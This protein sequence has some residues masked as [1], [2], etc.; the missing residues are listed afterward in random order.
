MKQEI[1]ASDSA[2]APTDNYLGI[3]FENAFWEDVLS[4]CIYPP[5]AAFRD[6]EQE[7]EDAEGNPIP[8]PE[9]EDGH[10]ITILWRMD[11]PE[12][13]R[14][15]R[16]RLYA[17][18]AAFA[19]LYR[20]RVA[21]KDWLRLVMVRYTD[22]LPHRSDVPAINFRLWQHSFMFVGDT[23]TLA[24]VEGREYEQSLPAPLPPADEAVCKAAHE[25]WRAM[26]N[27]R[28]K[29]LLSLIHDAESYETL[30]PTIDEWRGYSWQL[31]GGYDAALEN[32]CKRLQFC[33]WYAEAL[34]RIPR[35]NEKGLCCIALPS[36]GRLAVLDY[37]PEE[38]RR[39]RYEGE[40]PNDIPAEGKLHLVTSEE[41]EALPYDA[42]KHLHLLPIP[43]ESPCDYAHVGVKV[44]TGYNENWLGCDYCWDKPT[45]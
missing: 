13:K 18:L 11:E 4:C 22:N 34:R 14:Q 15:Q 45:V 2:L 23:F 21:R 12:G 31:L 41:K 16:P 26:V 19:H 39:F 27:T 28:I 33:P 20:R 29:Y 36:I 42:G 35:L 32:D 17:I 38:G 43:C 24:Q 7:W 30:M 5:D 37:R 44:C 1:T 10:R 8:T 6:T 3:E 25:Q 9:G 40:N